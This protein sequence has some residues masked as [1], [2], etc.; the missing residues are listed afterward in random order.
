MALEPIPLRRYLFSG[1]V[2]AIMLFTAMAAL[3]AGLA[4]ALLIEG[5][6][7]VGTI[8]LVVAPAMTLIGTLSSVLLNLLREGSG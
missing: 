5:E 3:G 6:S 2:I 7:P 1:I 8:A 4:L